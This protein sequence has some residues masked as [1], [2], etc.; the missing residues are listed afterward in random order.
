MKFII[1]KCFIFILVVASSVNLSAT[2]VDGCWNTISVQIIKYNRSDGEVKSVMNLDE[3]QLDK[4]L[5]YR[6]SRAIIVSLCL[7]EDGALVTTQGEKMYDG[8]FV[9]NGNQLMVEGTSMSGEDS[10][11]S[12]WEFSFSKDQ[13]GLT[14]T[15]D[16]YLDT[17]QGD[18]E[19]ARVI[20]KLVDS[21]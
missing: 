21:Y 10:A 5:D 12:K 8:S 4:I 1:L 20:I 15:E 2:E 18:L 3:S 9:V 11:G 7:G 16:Y 19:K 14:L 13:A 17:P 6:L